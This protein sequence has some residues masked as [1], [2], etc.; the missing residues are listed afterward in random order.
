[1]IDQSPA[2]YEAKK[3]LSI[4]K[5]D[6]TTIRNQMI[7]AG[8][9]LTVF[10]RFKD[11]VVDSV[12]EFFSNETIIKDG[13]LIYRRADEFK[14]LIKER[15]NGEAGQ[16]T[17]RVFRAALN[18]FYELQAISKEELADIERI[19]SLRND[20]GHELYLII[21]DD[22]KPSIR[23][24]DVLLTFAIYVKIVRWWIREIEASTDPDMTQEKF[25]AINFDASESMETALLREIISKILT[26][27]P[28]YDEIVSFVE[29]HSQSPSSA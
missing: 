5:E 25:E 15:G 17:N 27:I 28:E 23:V 19:Y 14:K 2:I 10:E 29:V 4:F 6:G 21:A 3:I 7:F 16:H 11:Y 9:L 22:R 20:I 1:M 26:G 8:I 18:W 12:N 13:R 24:W